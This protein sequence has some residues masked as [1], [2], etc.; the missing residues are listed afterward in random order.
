MRKRIQALDGLRGIAVILVVA[1]H[2]SP[3]LVLPQTI[4]WKLL[5]RISGGGWFGVD[6]FFVLSGFLITSI[7]LNDRGDWKEFYRNRAFRIL[8]AFLA[9]FCVVLAFIPKPHAL[10]F[11]AYLLFVGNFTVLGNNEITPLGHLWSLAVEEQ[12][13]LI[14]PQI[15][16]RLSR[17]TILKIA[18][19]IATVSFLCRVLGAILG[20]N[21]YLIYKITPMRLD[22]IALG[23]AVAAAVEIPSARD[24][25]N[26]RWKTA[27]WLAAAVLMGG[28]VA[29]KLSLF[30]WDVRAQMVAIPA[31]T[32]LTAAMVFAASQR[33]LPARLSS[34][35]CSRMFVYF[36]RR[37]YGLYLIHLPVAYALA[38]RFGH[39][40]GQLR[41]IPQATA[42]IAIMVL[43]M[44]L[45]VALA[46]LS[47]RI[48][49]QPAQRL[50]KRLYKSVHENDEMLSLPFEM[51]AAEERQSLPA[52]SP[53][54][55]KAPTDA[56]A[57]S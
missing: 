17:S 19:S 22:G 42:S 45:S 31:V 11:F 25:L 35:L 46:E 15:A 8:P 13:Y 40:L 32:I 7:L 57:K 9:V 34:V 16:W 47:W 30:A 33:L 1:S 37:S 41:P 18:L 50:K 54:S 29:L 26:R 2:F 52:E 5:Q 38:R 23:C 36:G 21:A 44:A 55:S 14:W 51:T 53:L 49:E 28:I 6:I 3:D 12:F 4:A 24:W 10:V 27:A 39:P 20:V 48:V 43:G 56:D